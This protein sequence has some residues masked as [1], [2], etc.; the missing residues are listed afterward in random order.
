MLPESDRDPC[1]TRSRR[2][3]TCWL[4]ATLAGPMPPDGKPISDSSKSSGTVGVG[5]AGEAG[6]VALRFRSRAPFLIAQTYY[7]IAI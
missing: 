7:Q 3:T 6:A 1:A 2:D 5:T 4:W